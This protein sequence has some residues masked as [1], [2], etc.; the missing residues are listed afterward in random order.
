MPG[1]SQV[2]GEKMLSEKTPGSVLG[3]QRQTHD[4]E[5]QGGWTQGNPCLLGSVLTCPAKEHTQGFLEGCLGKEAAAFG[6]DPPCDPQTPVH[7]N[8][9]L[10]NLEIKDYF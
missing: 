1:W 8:L 9:H 10:N 2:P 7:A 5:S 3:K 6:K 4:R